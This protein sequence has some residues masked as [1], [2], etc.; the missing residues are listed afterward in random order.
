[1]AVKVLRE[2]HTA[3]MQKRAAVKHIQGRISG[4]S[5]FLAPSTKTSSVRTCSRDP[6]SSSLST[7]RES[8]KVVG[9]GTWGRGACEELV[10][11]RR[12]GNNE[13]KE[14]PME[15]SL[16]ACWDLEAKEVLG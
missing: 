12:R 9:W 5:W 2:D 1:M 3:G 16:Q 6:S 13:A 7:S 8:E 11:F 15:L 4:L 14:K 10:T